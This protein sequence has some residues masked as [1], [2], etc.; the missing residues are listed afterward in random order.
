M[1]A[2]GVAI[3]IFVAF[4]AVAVLAYLAYKTIGS[5]RAV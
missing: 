4:A 2:P 5:R 3:I 1:I